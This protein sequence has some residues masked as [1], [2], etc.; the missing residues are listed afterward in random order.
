MTAFN[1]V[2]FREK[3]SEELARFLNPKVQL[4]GI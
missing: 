3:L 4:T 2:L 1:Q